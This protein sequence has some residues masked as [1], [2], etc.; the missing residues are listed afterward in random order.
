MSTQIRIRYFEYIFAIAL[1][2]LS[3][4]DLCSLLSY[5]TDL[6]SCVLACATGL[7][8]GIIILL[9]KYDSIIL[10]TA[11]VITTAFAV[12]TSNGWTMI[13]FFFNENFSGWYK[14]TDYLSAIGSSVLLVIAAIVA[15]MTMNNSITWECRGNLLK[16]TYI[17]AGLQLLFSFNSFCDISLLLFVYLIIPCLVKTEVKYN[18]IL[19]LTGEISFSLALIIPLLCSFKNIDFSNTLRII[20]DPFSI[21]SLTN[22]YDHSSLSSMLGVV[23]TIA[24]MLSPLMA[25]DRQCAMEKEAAYELDKDPDDFHIRINDDEE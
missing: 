9:R 13:K 4:L 12:Y 22:I 15:L 24:L 16:Y 1:I 7:V 8:T 17:M 18:S 14:T 21:N 20:F 10:K 11:F 25:F 6:F 3:T 2:L 19:G 5:I 23:C